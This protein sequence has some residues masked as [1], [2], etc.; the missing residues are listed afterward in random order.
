[1]NR[2]SYWWN[3]LLDVFFPRSCLDCGNPVEGNRFAY[4]CASCSRR[5]IYA[6]PPCCQTCGY[7]VYGQVESAR[8]CPHCIHLE[9][10]YEAGRVAALFQGPVRSLIHA[11]KYEQAEF[12]VPDLARLASESPDYLA[13]VRD[14]ILVPVP[15]HPRKLRERGYNQSDLIARAVCRAAGGG[16][17]RAG[18]LERVLDTPSQTRYARKERQTNLKNAFALVKD[19]PIM[20]AERYVIV[21]DVFTTGST[22]NACAEVLRRSGV[23]RIDVAT[24]GHG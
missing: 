11:L 3:G 8:S 20:A 6:G 19:A 18:L 13:F 1:M 22:L 4:L 14:A 7:P 16:T 2:L 12:V 21:D 9:P 10:A 17:R 24:I 15:L 23:R 5:V